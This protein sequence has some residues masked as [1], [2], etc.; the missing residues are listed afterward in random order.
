[1]DR[2][3][4]PLHLNQTF[5]S[6]V[7]LLARYGTVSKGTLKTLKATQLAYRTRVCSYSVSAE[8]PLVKADIQPC[9]PSLGCCCHQIPEGEGRCKASPYPSTTPA[10]SLQTLNPPIPP[11]LSECEGK[12]KMWMN[13]VSHSVSGYL[14]G[15]GSESKIRVDLKKDRNS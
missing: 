14:G 4:I 9:S 13:R 8:P 5:K 7:E 6:W 11:E 15:F 10:C 1:M 3:S 2:Y 12:A